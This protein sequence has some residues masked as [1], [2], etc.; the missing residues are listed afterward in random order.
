M[1]S[2]GRINVPTTHSDGHDGDGHGDSESVVG[3][4][5][6]HRAR[7]RSLRSGAEQLCGGGSSAG[8]G[9]HRKINSAN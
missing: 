4:G 6:V 2:S 8:L 9:R 3:S 1:Q 7:R 5:A